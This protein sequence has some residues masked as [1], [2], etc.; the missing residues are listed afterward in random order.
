MIHP[1]DS[2]SRILLRPSEA[3]NAL[4]VSL[5]CLMAWVKTGDIPVTRLGERCLRFSVDA[6]KTW[7]ASRSIWPTAIT[8]LGVEQSAVSPG[9][10][11]AAGNVAASRAANGMEASRP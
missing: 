4:G 8:S 7:V 9:L 10:S 6:L 11:G 2:S 3:A 1:A 5:R